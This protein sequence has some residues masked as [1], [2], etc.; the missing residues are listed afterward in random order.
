MH[1]S[2]SIDPDDLIK[3]AQKEPHLGLMTR[4][5]GG[6]ADSSYHTF[7]HAGRYMTEPVPKYH[8]PDHGMSE[9]AAYQLLSDELE[10]DGR[11]NLN[12]A[13]FVHTWMPAP[14]HRLMSETMNVNLSDQDE[15][16]ATMAV[17]ARC[18]SILSHLWKQPKVKS[19]SGES[20]AALGTSTTGSS[21]AIMLG[22]LAAKRRWQH[23]RKEQGKSIHEPGPNIVFGSNVQVAIEK[24]AR[25]WEVEERPVPIDEESHFCLSPKRAIEHVDENTI[26][27]VVILGSTYT[28][29]YEPVEEMAQELDAFQER[30]GIDVPIHVDG[31][32]GAMVAPF[33]T[34][35]VKWSF[36]IP[37]VASINTS[38]HKFGMVYPGLGWI[39]F[40]SPAL[41]P[42]ELVFE[43]HYL[44]SV[45]YSF[46]LNFSRPAAPVLGQMFNFLSLGHAGYRQTM[47]ANLQNAR[48]L[49]R[50]LELSGMFTLLSEIHRPLSEEQK[51]AHNIT[52]TDP[53]DA[54]LY[55]PG[56]PVVSFRWTDEFRREHPNLQQHWMQTLLRV[57]GW[58]VPNYELSPNMQNVQVLRVVVRDSM[59][60]S[61]VDTLVHDI[62]TASKELA[63]GSAVVPLAG[64]QSNSRVAAHTSS[65]HS[66][67]SDA[68]HGRP[69]GH[70]ARGRGYSK[71]C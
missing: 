51:R 57:R 43:L 11:P 49:S 16:P 56:L 14:A 19:E 42:K 25:Y 44:G 70:G 59:T 10:L 55:T 33:A 71:Q 69:H 66:K 32:S 7:A 3:R 37:R 30:T 38:G 9:E 67:R 23:K 31:A 8:M 24:F 20:N 18:I 45:E 63:S 53:N 58:I 48:L 46:G 68:D 1:L 13:S 34:P 36:D 12:L 26:A 61:M 54:Q 29:H 64:Q 47:N 41:V 60:E 4:A 28:G 2:L 17:Q 52:S 35:H 15:Y 5:R 40:R 62:I 39:I 65:M 21:E 22:L 27:V 50:A 6:S